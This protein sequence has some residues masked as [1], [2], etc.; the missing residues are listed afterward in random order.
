MRNKNPGHWNLVIGSFSTLNQKS[1]TNSLAHGPKTQKN[2]P[3]Y[4]KPK[5]K[6]VT[7]KLDF[8]KKIQFPNHACSSINRFSLSILR[9]RPMKRVIIT[10]RC[11]N[12]FLFNMAHTGLGFRHLCRCVMKLVRLANVILGS[13]S[14]WVGWVVSA[15]RCWWLLWKFG[16]LF[17]PTRSIGSVVLDGCSMGC[18]VSEFW[19]DL[20]I[21]VSV[22]RLRFAGAYCG[23]QWV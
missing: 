19:S 3:K 10:L 23:V 7:P 16:F 14:S 8:L 2:A 5:K 18:L 1:F 22:S 13:S 6:M 15:D 21:P 20:I 4:S 9:S 11:V 12:T 17:F